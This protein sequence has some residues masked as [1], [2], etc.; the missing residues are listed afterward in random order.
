MFLNRNCTQFHDII[1]RWFVFNIYYL[2]QDS[3]RFHV[4]VA[5]F[6]EKRDLEEKKRVE[7][8]LF[9]LQAEEWWLFQSLPLSG[10][11]NFDSGTCK[12]SGFHGSTG[13][14]IK[15]IKGSLL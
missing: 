11:K 1:E 14:C 2:L 10:E 4:F 8:M 15:I 12:R 6:Q 7:D 3:E 13:L 9:L 5:Q